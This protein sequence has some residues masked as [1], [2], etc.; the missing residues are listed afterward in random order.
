MIDD[1]PGRI[2]RDHR[3]LVDALHEARKRR[4][5]GWIAPQAADHFDEA[6]QRRWVEEMQAADALRPFAA[7]RD[8]GHRQ[9]GRIGG[10][11]AVSRHTLFQRAEQ[12]AFGRKVFDDGLDD[13]AGPLRVVERIDRLQTVQQV[14]FGRGS[15]AL[16]DHQAFE[17]FIDRRNR[18]LHR[19]VTG[20][21]KQR[22]DTRLRAHLRDAAAHGAG[23]EYGN[24]QIRL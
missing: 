2:G 1:E 22:G 15:H 21:E 9:R 19:A 10:E 4:N 14:F 3:M 8:L 18:L 24:D 5:Q 6:H 23:A 11:H 17:T 20:I 13:D 12:L 16:L 7:G